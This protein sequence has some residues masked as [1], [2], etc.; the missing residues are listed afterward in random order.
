MKANRVIQSVLGNTRIS[1]Q[2]SHFYFFS[3]SKLNEARNGQRSIIDE[4]SPVTEAGSQNFISFKQLDLPI[5]FFLEVKQ[6]LT[7]YLI[8]GCCPSDPACF[9]VSQSAVIHKKQ[10]PCASLK[11]PL[12]TEPSACR[13]LWRSVISHSQVHKIFQLSW[14]NKLSSS[15]D[16]LSN[17]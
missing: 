16:M 2:G 17:I 13:C 10:Q 9:F 6:K 5:F 1:I 3:L 8:L 14:S 4:P 11:H 15:V 7:D 12:K